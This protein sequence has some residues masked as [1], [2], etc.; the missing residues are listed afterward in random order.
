MIKLVADYQKIL[1]EIILL[2]K[3]SFFDKHWFLM[4]KKLIKSTKNGS[5]TYTGGVNEL[6]ALRVDG[7]FDLDKIF[8][9][10]A[11]SKNLEFE[12]DAKK[13]VLKKN[14]KRKINKLKGK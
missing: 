1:Q 2:N 5:I 9:W 7:K 11:T 6:M 13:E 4:K 3:N 14:R 10:L 12:G 8:D